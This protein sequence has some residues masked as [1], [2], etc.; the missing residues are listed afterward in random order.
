M[1]LPY[2]DPFYGSTGDVYLETRLLGFLTGTPLVFKY[3]LGGNYP[4]PGTTHWITVPC[5]NKIYDTFSASGIVNQN[6]YC[7]IPIDGY[8]HIGGYARFVDTIGGTR[9][10]GFFLNRTEVRQQHWV[11][12]DAAGRYS[13]SIAFE[14]F[15]PAGS[16]IELIAIQD[17]GANIDIIGNSTF[18]SDTALLYGHRIG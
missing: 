3:A 8:Y 7:T 16:V 1:I 6:G 4:I 2:A 12:P 14:G 18:D 17:T 5:N 10:L 11:A 13:R 9:G 15:L